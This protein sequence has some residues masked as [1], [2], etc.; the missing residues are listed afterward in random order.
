MR[1][2]PWILVDCSSILKAC[3]YAGK[4]TEHGF[5]ATDPQGKT[6]WVN[7]WQFGL[8]NAISSVVSILQQSEAAPMDLIFVF[9]QDGSRIR[10]NI[11]PEYKGQR[12][13][14]AKE[15]NEQYDL[16]EQNLRAFF[17]PLG[18]QFV[19]QPGVEADDVVAYLAKNL[20]GRK[21]VAM[22]DADAFSLME[23]PDVE[24]RYKGNLIG[25]EL[26]NPVGPFPFKYIRLYKALVGDK[27][28][29]LKGA[30]GFGDKA[31]ID[32]YVMIGD[33]GLDAL[34]DIIQRGAFQELVEDAKQVKSIQKII[35]HRGSVTQSWKCAGFFDHLVNSPRARLQWEVGMVSECAGKPDKRL[36][37]WYQK[38]RLVHSGN[39]AQIMTSSIWMHLARSPFA[40]LDLE[41][42]TPQESDDWLR[43]VNDLS[44]DDPI[45]AVDVI[46]SKITGLG[47]T[48]GDNGQYTLYFTVNHKTDRNITMEQL[49]QFLTRVLQRAPDLRFNVH[50]SSFEL[51]VLYLNGLEW[52][53]NDDS[54]ECGFLP[55]VDDTIFMASY[56]N[57]NVKIGLKAQAQ[58][59]L[60]Y[61]QTTYADTV[62]CPN[63]G[64]MRKMDELTPDEVFAYGTDDTIV[65]WALRNHYQ[66]IMEL[67]GTFDLCR[68]VEM[69]AAYLCA[70]GLIEGVEFNREE[71]RKQEGEDNIEFDKHWAVVRKWLVDNKWDG[72]EMPAM[73]LSPASMKA[74]FLMVTGTSLVTQVRT[75]AKLVILMRE[76]GADVLADLYDAALASADMTDVERYVRTFH[77]GEPE[78]NLDSPAQVCKLL[79]EKLELPIRVR[80]KP[81]PQM[82]AQG[83]R[84]GNPAGN[85]LAMASALFYDCNG[86]DERSVVARTII[87][88]LIKMRGVATRR[89]MFYKPYRYLRHWKT[90]KIHGSLGQ[91]MTVTRRFAPSKP[92]LAQLPKDKGGFRA[93]FRPHHKNAVIVSLDFN[94]QELRVIADY[95]R[96]ENMVSCY[97]GENRKDLH[98]L[99]GLSIAQRKIRED[100]TYEEFAERIDDDAHVEHKLMVGTRKKAKTVNFATEYGAMADKLAE[101]LMV[102]VEEAQAYLEA[103]NETFWR[104]EQWKKEEVIPEARKQGYATTMLGG[105]RHLNEAFQS[106]DWGL[107]S[108]AE[109]Q[110]VNYKIQGSC[111]E[112]TKLAMGRVWRRRML[113]RYDAKFFAPIHDEL[114]FS[115]AIPDA[116]P[117]IVEL[118]EC[119][120]AKYA[121]MWI[122]LESSIGIGLDFKNLIEIGKEPDP[123]LIEKALARL[124]ER[125]EEAVSA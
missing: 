17:K 36:E 54:W 46:A 56:V 117:F 103:K 31:F 80:N 119:M 9:E 16:L 47:F 33:E 7:G 76:H 79:Y 3:L 58:R 122:P 101:T 97:V 92:N 35:D 114:V 87:S 13:P 42:S 43:L 74:A 5:E 77:K 22:N 116:V 102:P 15:W 71:M 62:R 29:N 106:G 111:A 121:N 88:S 67:E 55:R 89:K 27:S 61:E 28:D 108:R 6:V 104:S 94:A 4:D 95:S 51:P 98:H 1:N 57:E 84:E 12:T 60:G 45:A 65:T 83:I 112:M 85:A 120:I 10:R 26:E 2:R 113:Q 125:K 49:Y 73:D 38:R 68:T 99:T 123:A 21:V 24:V 93:C 81:T 66:A 118:H 82:K 107:E 75:P 78:I 48:F 44:E 91:C 69:D 37:D 50:N 105:V 39:F 32:L 8:E 53:L 30:V 25:S 14:K 96:D 52:T 63:T 70:A 86:D 34:I 109:R 90:G 100:M 41:T 59:V 110:A 124:A 115:V 19:V 40:T 64:R 20:K 11:Y 23:L 72:V 18:A